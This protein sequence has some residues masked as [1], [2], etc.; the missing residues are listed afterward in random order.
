[1]EF[2]EK[3][4]QIHLP[5]KPVVEPVAPIIPLTSKNLMGLVGQMPIPYA[6]KGILLVFKF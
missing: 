1:M 4:K 2:A 3:Q 5:V 6:H